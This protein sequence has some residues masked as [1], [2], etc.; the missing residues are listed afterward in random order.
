MKFTYLLIIWMVSMSYSLIAEDINPGFIQTLHQEAIIFDAHA[1]TPLDLIDEAIDFG[2]W[3]KTGHVDLMKMEMGGVDVQV[4]ALFIAPR[5]QADRAIQRVYDLMR[6]SE[7]ALKPYSNRIELCSKMSDIERCLKNDKK[8]IIY[9][10]E[11][12]HFITDNL[13][14]IDT[15]YNRGVRY[16]TLTWTNTN[17]WADAAGDSARW[18]GLNAF[19]EKVVERMNDLGILLDLSH[20]SDDTFW[21]ALKI[22][23]APALVSHSCCRALCEHERNLTDEMLKA[24]AKNGGVIGINF[25]PGFLDE[26]FKN[27]S[28]IVDSIIDAQLDSMK[29]FHAVESEE[30]KA[31]KRETYYKYHQTLPKLSIERLIDHIDHAVRIAGIDHV[32]LGSDFD[33]IG[34]VPEGLE[35]QGKLIIITEKLLQRGYGPEEIKKILGGNMMRL[36]KTVLKH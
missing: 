6:A 15:M 24:L 17:A 30:Y 25:Y 27:K 33:G 29:Q 8:V 13:D 22:T 10:I 3:R 19:G 28:V 21:D 7:E 20:V 23:R 1:D 11:G 12:G 18:G 31:F 16:I 14:I 35:H 26:D 36:F 2:K 5:Y 32:G 4:F 9:G 34:S